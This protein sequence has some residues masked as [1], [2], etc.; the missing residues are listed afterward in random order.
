MAEDDDIINKL[1]GSTDI[2]RDGVTIDKQNEK[3]ALDRKGYTDFIFEK[4][5]VIGWSNTRLTGSIVDNPS[6]LEPMPFNRDFTLN[7]IWEK[8]VTN[9]TAIIPG[10]SYVKDAFALQGQLE[11][12][13]ET[14]T[15]ISAASFDQQ[16]GKLEGCI[17]DNL[18]VSVRRIAYKASNKAL[19]V[20]LQGTLKAGE[21]I[22]LK[23]Y[24]PDRLQAL[25]VTGTYQMNYNYG[26]EIMDDFDL[27]YDYTVDLGWSS[28]RYHN[29][30]KITNTK[31][32]FAPVTCQKLH[33]S[34]TLYGYS[35]TSENDWSSNSLDIS[36]KCATSMGFHGKDTW[37]GSGDNIQVYSCAGELNEKVIEPFDWT[38]FQWFDESTSIN[39]LLGVVP[40]GCEMGRAIPP[41]EIPRGY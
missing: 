38:M 4:P 9:S 10:N 2:T 20:D 27:H 18:G 23:C 12:L 39:P 11:K 31:L 24:F 21:S 13:E 37:D 7:E 1:G 41:A 29:T 15:G 40:I 30:D 5:L 34:Y 35:L 22:L 8:D 17:V 26:L 3:D 6:Q 16:S 36:V 32:D 14:P 19:L 28:L 33:S 25:P